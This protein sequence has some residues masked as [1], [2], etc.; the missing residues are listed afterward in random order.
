[1]PIELGKIGDRAPRSLLRNTIG[2]GGRA[3]W[4]YP[5]RATFRRQRNLC[6]HGNPWIPDAEN[7][8]VCSRLKK[9]LGLQV[10]RN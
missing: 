6:C 10:A 5:N 7:L 9:P 8:A 4:E 3:N 1:M 2:A